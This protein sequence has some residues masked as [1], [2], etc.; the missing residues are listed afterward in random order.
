[1]P[2]YACTALSPLCPVCGAV[3]PWPTEPPLSGVPIPIPTLINRLAL[4]SCP[5]IKPSHWNGYAF[6]VIRQTSVVPA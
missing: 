4:V 1:M 2:T 3:L 6:F 5:M